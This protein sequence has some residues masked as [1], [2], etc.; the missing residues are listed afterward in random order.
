MIEETLPTRR[1]VGLAVFLVIAGLIGWIASFALTLE[2]IETLVNPNYVPSCNISVLVS[3]GPNMASPQG[4]LFGFPNP[5]I[6]VACFIAVIV[7]GVGILAGA[8]FARWF[9]MLFNLGIVFAL[10]FVIWLIGQ[11]I[12]VLGTLCPYCMVVWTMVIPLFWYVTVYNLREGNIPA[13]AGVRSIARLFFPFLWLF[14]IVSYLVVAV[15]AQLRL[16]VIASLTNS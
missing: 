5:L 9:W 16:D 14:V 7:V 4:S 11:S 13:P 2:K 10:V 3:C 1:P 8:T 15:L 6:G 12:F